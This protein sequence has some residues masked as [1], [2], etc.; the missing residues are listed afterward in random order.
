MVDDKMCVN[1]SGD[2]LMCRFDPLL[3]QE[4]SQLKGYLPMI[5]KGKEMKGYCYVSPDG[6]R[7]KK[8]LH[9]WLQ[10]CLQYNQEARSSK[11]KKGTV[12]TS[13]KMKKAPGA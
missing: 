7:T 12:K 3:Q 6:M 5:M 10:H 9:S 4:L 11:K 2:N 1:I 13:S 8:D